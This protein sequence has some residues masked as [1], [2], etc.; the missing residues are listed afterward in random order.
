MIL[1]STDVRAALRARIQRQRGFFALP[2]G[3]G[4]HRPSGGGGG[5]STWNPADKDADITLSGGNLVASI[6]G[7]ATGAV[8]G[9][10]SRPATEN[11]YF[12]VTLAGADLASQAAGICDAAASIASSLGFDV[13]GFGYIPASDAK[14]NSNASSDYLPDHATVLGVLVDFS[15]LTI[16]FKR[17]GKFYTHKFTFSAQTLYPAWG[18]GSS[19]GGPRAATINTG[20]SAWVLGLPPAAT[21]WGGTWNSA[22]KGANITLSNSDLTADC[23]SGNGNVRGTQGRNSGRYYFEITET[24]GDQIWLGGVANASATLS[25]YPGS[26]SNGWSFFA[27]NDTCYP[28][29]VGMPGQITSTTVGVWLNNGVLSFIGD[30]TLGGT[31]YSGITGSMFPAW[32]C[33]AGSGTRT[34]TLNVGGSAFVWP[35]PSGATAWG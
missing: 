31:A 25:N 24:V 20:G 8:R 27:L 32:S 12:E 15:A 2:G 10:T 7:P 22:D 5:V 13:T 18:P 6:T 28:G 29:G 26:D 3:M 34:G 30:G 19:G 14:Q 23:A 35:L 21:A 33:T 16:T 4:A 17:S 1:R 9:I 11:R